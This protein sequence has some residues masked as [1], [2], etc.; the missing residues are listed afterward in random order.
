MNN[1]KI[2]EANLSDIE[3]LL[4]LITEFWAESG[5]DLDRSAANAAF[6]HLIGDPT[7][8]KIWLARN[9]DSPVG[10]IVLTFS[11][12]FEF[13]GHV[14][15]V[16]DLFVQPDSRGSGIGRKLLE[17]LIRECELRDIKA[18]HV[19]A[20][21]TNERA[22]GLYSSYGLQDTDRMLLTRRFEK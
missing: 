6:I 18:L 19:E 1:V 16:D 13:F 11:F 22:L 5:Y 10:Y 3:Q 9:D 12:S 2:R 17:T 4:D 21:D 15:F 14:A 8:G 7:L 20:G